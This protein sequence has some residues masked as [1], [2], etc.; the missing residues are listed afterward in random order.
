MR[1]Q[2]QDSLLE[3]DSQIRQ[4]QGMVDKFK[5]NPHTNKF[6]K[7]ASKLNSLLIQQEAM[8]C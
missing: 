3:K 7:E 2:H 1:L 8:F 6:T 4:M 5:H